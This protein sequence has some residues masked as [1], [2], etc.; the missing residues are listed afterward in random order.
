[1]STVSIIVGVIQ[2]ALALG[3]IALVMMQEGNERGL[4]AI[5]GGAET[6]FGKNAANT[7]EAKM[8]KNTTIVGIAFILATIALYFVGSIG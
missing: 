8:R 5:A 7:P 1:M 3:V 2:M 6:F 4:G